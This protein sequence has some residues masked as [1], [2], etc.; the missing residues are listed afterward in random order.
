VFDW[1]PE[2]Y[3]RFDS[4]R[5]RPAIDLLGQVQHPDP[6]LIYDVGTGRGQI[7]RLMADRWPEAVVV[8]T[9]TSAEMLEAA[10][11]TS[12]RVRWVEQDVR[13]WNPSEPPDIIYSN[14]V[15]HW[16]HDHDELLVRLVE[17]LH[18]GGVL[19]VQMPLSWHE[20][21]HRLMREILAS[22]RNGSP[23]GPQSLRQ[24]MADPPV[25]SPGHYH[26]LLRTVA[27]RV[28][29]WQTTYYQELTG[30]DAV[31][32]WVRGTALRPILDGLEPD[33]LELFLAVYRI[34]LDDAYPP[35]ADGR[36]IYPF[37]RVF[38]VASRGLQN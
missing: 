18:P 9:D 17:S 36:T 21:S 19:A 32:E 1:D 22:G 12:T 27:D 30:P 5:S 28:N 4:H 23:L 11:P 35:G 10:G 31:L 16:V 29:V 20:P 3:S 24:Q 37:P 38:M 33:D 7:A 2:I 8:G 25:A 26:R 6:R 15:L 14:A 13:Q 34:A